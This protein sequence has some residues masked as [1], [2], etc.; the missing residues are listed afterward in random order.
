MGMISYLGHKASGAWFWWNR[1]QVKDGPDGKPVAVGFL[2]MMRGIDEKGEKVGFARSLMQAYRFGRE[3]G[4]QHIGL[5]EALKNVKFAPPGSKRRYSALED[6]FAADQALGGPGPAMPGSGRGPGPD[7]GPSSGG[8]SDGARATKDPMDGVSIRISTPGSMI[9]RDRETRLLPGPGMAR[10][11]AHGG[12]PVGAHVGAR[13]LPEPPKAIG[14]P[15][16][17]LGAPPKA[18]AAPPKAISG[19]KRQSGG[20]ER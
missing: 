6:A 3:K 7:R 11:A 14:S 20:A 1:L 5:T 17:A 15:P 2:S 10:K 13:A 16:K 4:K 19:P 12:A 18:I 9:D 8:P